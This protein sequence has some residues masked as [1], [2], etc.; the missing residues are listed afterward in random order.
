MLSPSPAML[1]TRRGA[2]ASPLPGASFIVNSPTSA[3]DT[4]LVSTGTGFGLANGI[5]LL[6]K[7]GGEF[8]SRYSTYAGTGTVRYVW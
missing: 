8:A 2:V 6:A 1:F 5:A 4:A 3:R 7:V